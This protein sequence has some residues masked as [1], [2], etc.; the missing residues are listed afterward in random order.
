MFTK[1]FTKWPVFFFAFET[2]QFIHLVSFLRID[3]NLSKIILVAE[4]AS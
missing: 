2:L 1:A 4:A 3:I